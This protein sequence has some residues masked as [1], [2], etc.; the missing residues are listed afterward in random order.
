MREEVI[1]EEQQIADERL[2]DEA[3]PEAVVLRRTFGSCPRCSPLSCSRL[4]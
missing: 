1:A 4:R 2:R 3:R